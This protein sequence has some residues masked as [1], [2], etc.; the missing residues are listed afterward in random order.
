MKKR[1]ITYVA[2][3]FACLVASCTEKEEN[4]NDGGKPQTFVPFAINK[5]VNISNWLSQVNAIPTNGFSQAEAQKLAE[6][7]FDHIRLPIDE[8]LFFTEAGEKIPEAFT[9]LHNAIGWCRDAGMKVIVDLH[10]LRDHNF[11][12]TITTPGEPIESF[13]DTFE[14]NGWSNWFGNGPGVT[15]NNIDNP[16]KSNI[17]TSNR[18]FMVER[19]TGVD[20]WSNAKKN[21]FGAISVGEGKMQFK[22]LRAKIYKNTKSVITIVLGDEN[23][24]NESYYGYTNTTE[25]QWEEIAV[26]VSNYNRNCG[27]VAIRPEEGETIYFDDVFFSDSKT[28]DNKIYPESGSTTTV[29]PKLWTDKEAQ[30]KYLDLWKML[31]EE[32]NQYPNDLIAYEL[33]NEPVAPYASQ[34][35][36]LAALLIRELRQTEPERKLIIGSNRWQSVNTFNELT[37]PAGDPNIIL[38]FHFYNPHPLTHY[39]AEWTEEKD[40]NVPIHYPGVLVE[41]DDFN[42]LSEAMQKLLQPYMGTYDKTALEAL[43]MKAEMKAAS[44]GVQLNCGEFGCYK[45][46]PAADRMQWIRDV[47][48]ILRDRNISYSYWEYK[49][50]FGFCDLHGNVI[51]QEVLDLLTK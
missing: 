50:G 13:Y 14:D 46:T 10:V 22:Y 29:V 44:L 18:V 1:F 25:N 12:T 7:G 40:L 23:N 19:K 21:N 11:N 42:Q 36:S 27:R 5:G 30:Y 4:I 38:S 26:D 20:T 37:I 34:W 9:L 6:F 28:G 31:A 51:E 41:E 8:K 33:L 48:S 16:Y 43:V 49:A 15:V 2:C 17:N 32:L 24:A 3:L 35:N 45:K 47:V 39:Q